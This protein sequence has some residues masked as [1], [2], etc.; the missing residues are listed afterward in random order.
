MK[1]QLLLLY[2]SGVNLDMNFQQNLMGIFFQMRICM[3][4]ER[5]LV[6]M[7]EEIVINPQYVQKVFEPQDD[8][9]PAPS[10]GQTSSFSVVSP[11]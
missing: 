4:V 10:S 1:L 7:E 5:R 2:L 6:A 9:S 11:M 3:E 8:E